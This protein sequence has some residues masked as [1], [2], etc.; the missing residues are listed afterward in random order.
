[1]A[2]TLNETP[3]DDNA[4]EF[5]WSMVCATKWTD[6]AHRLTLRFD[7]SLDGGKTWSGDPKGETVW[8]WG[9]FPQ[10]Y[11]L[12]GNPKNPDAGDLVLELPKGA[13]RV[14]RYTAVW[15]GVTAPD[16]QMAATCL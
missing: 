4:K 2:V 15:E 5:R 10:T 14:V 13:N 12:C 8:P 3:I 11:C 16:Y 7:L 9:Q 6:P 1:M